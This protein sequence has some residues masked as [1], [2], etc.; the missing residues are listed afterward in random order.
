MWPRNFFDK[1]DVCHYYH[2]YSLF[3]IIIIIYYYNCSERTV[4]LWTP[5]LWNIHTW[6]LQRLI[7]LIF[8]RCFTSCTEGNASS[9]VYTGV[10]FLSLNEPEDDMGWHA[11]LQVK[12]TITVLIII[13][14]QPEDHEAR[15]FSFDAVLGASGKAI[16]LEGFKRFDLTFI[17]LCSDFSNLLWSGTNLMPS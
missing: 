7:I 1:Y 4:V 15:H 8:R 6:L 16:N 14:S 10:K 11:R 13:F 3:T 9:Q 5:F 17:Y 2:Y 12:I